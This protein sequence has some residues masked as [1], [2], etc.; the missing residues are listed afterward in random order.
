MM[1]TGCDCYNVGG[2]CEYADGSNYCQYYD[3]DSVN[4][5]SLNDDDD[6]MHY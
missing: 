6:I 5:T 4:A 3:G 2:G 1:S